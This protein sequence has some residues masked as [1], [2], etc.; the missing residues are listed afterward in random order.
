MVFCSG[1]GWISTFVPEIFM[2]NYLPFL[3]LAFLLAACYERNANDP[4]AVKEEMRQREIVHLTPAQISERAFK[5]GD[6]LCEMAAAGMEKE[7]KPDKDSSCVRAFEVTKAWLQQEH[8]AQLSRLSF[9]PEGLKKLSSKKEKEVFD[10]ILYNRENHLPILPNNQKDCDKDFIFT[11]ALV[12]REKNCGNCHQK[13]TSP[14]LKG[15]TGD[16]LGIWKVRFA[17]KKVVLSFVD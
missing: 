3:S 16:T 10:A 4:K 2:K 5:I 9:Q 11:K 14:W 8:E 12:L 15:K 6:T 1:Q 17:K 13:M 7:L